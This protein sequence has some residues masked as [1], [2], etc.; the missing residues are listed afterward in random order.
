MRFNR[1]YT[2]FALTLTLC[3]ALSFTTSSVNADEPTA[4]ATVSQATPSS[5]FA[6]YLPLMRTLAQNLALNSV[7]GQV[8]APFM[9]HG[10]H[11]V[12]DAETKDPAQSG[13]VI[14]TF[15]VATSGTYMLRMLVDAPND[16]A[17]SVFVSVNNPVVQEVHTWHIAP[18]SGFETRTVGY[19]ISVETTTANA[20][21]LSAGRH[22]VIVAGRERGVRIGRIWLDPATAPVTPTPPPGDKLGGTYGPPTLSNPKTI[23]LSNANPNYWG[24]GN[25]DVIVRVVEKITVP[26]KV[27]NVRNLVL[28]G[29]EFTINKPLTAS[30]PNTQDSVRQHRA[31][32][33]SDI[34]GTLYV[35]GIHV[36]NSGGGLTEG[37]QVWNVPGYVILRNSRIEGVRTK[38]NDPGFNFNHPDLF[39]PMSGRIVLENVTLADSD[40]QGMYIGREPGQT[41]SSV[42]FRNVNTRNV[43]MQAWFFSNLNA[44]VVRSCE[45]CWHGLE[46]SRYT[47]VPNLAFFPHPRQTGD[48]VVWSGFAAVAEGLSIRLG[49]PAGGDFVPASVVGMNYDRSYFE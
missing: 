29:G 45:N 30:L 13:R 36:N 12:Y 15:D 44:G 4:P 10:D 7:D 1:W 22:T 28:I 25:E 24:N 21:T 32:A 23:L 6:I 35:E 3:M 34:S 33:F 31:L 47:S 40:Y 42:E 48:R 17:N 8:T 9:R 18:T 20:F 5:T 41:I 38:P 39:Q 49:M 11:I 26:A 43:Y 27:G 37:F 19:G 16:S 46:N 2:L 14:V